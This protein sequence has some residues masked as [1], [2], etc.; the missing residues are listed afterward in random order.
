[1]RR[2]PI[3]RMTCRWFAAVAGFAIPWTGAFAGEAEPTVVYEWNPAAFRAG[4]PYQATPVVRPDGRTAQCLTAPGGEWNNYLYVPQGKLKGGR[5]YTALVTYE[6]V[7]PTV[8]PGTFYMFARSK[9]LGQHCDL[10]QTW[11]GEAGATGTARLSMDLKPADDWVFFVGCRGPGAQIIDRFRIVEGN[12]FVHLPAEAG[13][14]PAVSPGAPVATGSEEIVIEPPAA[15]GGP[16]LS[17]TDFGLVADDPAGPAEPDA[18]PD[19]LGAVKRAIDAC[20]AQGASRLVFPKGVYRFQAREALPFLNLT[21]IVVDGQGSEFLFRKLHP[22]VAAVTLMECDHVVLRDL[23]LDW[24]WS[25]TP[26]ASL[27]RVTGVAA[28]GMGCDLAFPDLDEAEVER[29]REAPWMQFFP[30]DPLEFR[31]QSSEKIPSPVEGFEALPGNR[32]RVTFKQPVPLVEGR[33][34]CIRHQYY[35]MSAFRVGNSRHL[36]FDEVTIHSMPGMGWVFRDDMSHWG[37]RNCKIARREGSRRPVTTTADG[38]HVIESRG[39]LLLENCEF[40]GI[41]EDNLNIHDNCAQGVRRVD[42]R[43]LVLVGN[44]RW[45]MRAEAGH[46]IALYRPDFSPLG[47]QSRIDAVAYQGNDTVLTLAEPL[48]ESVP[49]PTL[50]SNLH[51]DTANVRIA[52]CRFNGGGRI[53]TS[54]RNLTIE[55]CVFDHTFGQAV[56]LA[57]DI[58]PPHWAE[59]RPASNVVLRRNVF[60]SVNG[61]ARADGAAVCT[62]TRW[63]AGATDAPLYRNLLIEG[64][65]FVNTA[66]PALSLHNC[67]AV[68][69]RDN[70]IDTAGL[71]GVGMPF[72]A[73]ILTTRS[74]DL[75]LGGNLWKTGPVGVVPGVVLDPAT[76]VRVECAGNR[77]EP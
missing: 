10:W 38:L 75:A 5:G 67:Q 42:D 44:N 20:R 74:A 17:A 49:G 18:A 76:T 64:N 65:R 22:G 40:N 54:A 37:L 59:G 31:I 63:P 71:K 4:P 32:L 28:D 6:I 29:V 3:P 39:N 45:R 19:N 52:N 23:R 69:V 47:Y 66:G 60:D 35:D 14:S 68:T 27:C 72:P 24:D 43:T 53:L 15:T 34:Y 21:N 73:A 70:V 11:L 9:S 62:F 12:G 41:F 55:D 77:V 7:T 1:M 30:V 58:V 57:I 36:L 8:F 2:M 25:V 33:T 51:F 61:T 48:P 26:L 13:E 46:A 16:V 50:V 56:Q